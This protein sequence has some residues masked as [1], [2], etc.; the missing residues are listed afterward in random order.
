MATIILRS[1]KGSPLTNDEVDANFNN[2]NV[3]LGTKLAANAYTAAD[4]LTKL[5][6]V[7][8]SG[9]GL[10][11]DSLRGQKFYSVTPGAVVVSSVSRSSNTS[12]ATASSA[13]GYSIGDT[14]NVFG[15][16]PVTFN[17]TF[18]VLG[19]PSSTTFTY[20]Q[21]GESNVSSTAQTN[22]RSYKTITEAS[23][24]HRDINGTVS[25]PTL[26][27]KTT[28]SN[29]VG[30]VTGNVTGSVTGNASNVT[31]TIAVSNG[32]TGGT[33]ASEARTGLGLGSLSTQNSNSVAITGGTITGLTNSLA[34]TDGGTGAN[35]AASARTNLGLGNVTNESKSTMFTNPIFTGTVTASAVGISGGLQAG[36]TTV[37]SL[38]ST[39][40]V[41]DSK[42]NVRTIPVNSQASPY[43]LTLTDI[44]KSVLAGDDITIPNSVFSAGDA[45][46][47]FNNTTANITVTLNTSSAY[48]SGSTINKTVV[49]LRGYGLATVFFLSSTS[50]VI[51]GSVV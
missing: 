39:N 16:L 2:L 28:Y 51:S 36:A 19:V 13:H 17:G 18:T 45:I 24:P 48:I 21:N 33:T 9:S 6:T 31:G 14:V 11:A 27:A 1:V 50:C 8:G 5:K 12:T 26:V 3:E 46:T 37:A 40:G 15:I 41:S 47:I 10:D 25:T 44:G 4:I 35:N 34:V 23:I 42:G 22:G 49:T 29:L 32:G 30:N 43:T 20:T 7:D 38:A